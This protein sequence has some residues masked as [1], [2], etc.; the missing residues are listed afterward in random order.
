MANLLYIHK[1]SDLNIKSAEIESLQLVRS[2]KQS[3]PFPLTQQKIAVLFGETIITNDDIAVIDGSLQ[4]LQ[5]TLARLDGLLAQGNP[6]HEPVNLRRAIQSLN[7]LAAPLANSLAYSRAILALQ[8][9][10][11]GNAAALLNAI[12]TLRT[13]EEKSRLNSKVSMY[14][15]SVLRSNGFTFTHR[16][17]VFEAHTG[18]VLDLIGSFSKGYLFHVTL[19]EEL[20]KATFDDIKKRIPLE[21]LQESDSIAASIAAIK[22][23]VDRAY[24]INMRMI[25]WAIIFLS[26]IKAASSR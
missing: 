23:G 19:E 3:S 17:I 2:I 9:D 20:K 4:L 14:F 25:Q 21:K 5:P 13:S 16:D 1:L 12:P 7:S 8:G 11:L 6:V 26:L 18:L 10:F 15:E 24:S 22:E